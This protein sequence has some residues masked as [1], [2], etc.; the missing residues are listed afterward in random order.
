[1][2]FSVAI[3]V[4]SLLAVGECRPS[5]AEGDLN[6][7]NGFHCVKSD[8]CIP[9]AWRCDL[10]SD[11]TYGEDEVG[12]ATNV[13]P[14][15]HFSCEEHGQCFPN[16]WL[17]DGQ[18]DCSNGKDEANCAH[19]N[20]TVSQFKCP[21]GICLPNVLTCDGEEDCAGGEDE[22][23]EACSG[24]CTKDSGRFLCKSTQTCVWDFYL[25]DGF[26]DCPGGEDELPANCNDDRLTIGD[27]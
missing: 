11:C 14:D 15:S 24:G 16:D 4:A 18:N 6:A 1:M 22:T 9:F 8:E 5:N 13:C 17:C 2:Y 10:D 21:D 7:C 12:C 26:T 3:A 27:Y 25:C 20:C 19:R 23:V